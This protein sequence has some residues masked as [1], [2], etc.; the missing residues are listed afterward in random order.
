MKPIQLRFE[1]SFFIRWGLIVGMMLMMAMV[2]VL[3]MR[4][5]GW[6]KLVMPVGAL[7][8]L[9]LPLREWRI[10]AR[11][12]DDEGVTRHDGKRFLWSELR[13]L[14]E[15]NFVNRYGQTGSLNHLDIYFTNGRARILP[16]V[17]DRG[18]EAIRHIQQRHGKPAAA[19][20][21]AAPPA[22]EPKPEAKPTRCSLCG[23]LGEYHHAM[24]KHG[25]EEQDTSLPPAVKNLKFV[26]DLHP[27]TTRSPELLRCPGCGSYFLFKIS[28]EYLATG[29]EDEQELSRMTQQ[30]ADEILA[31][32]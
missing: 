5:G 6:W 16:M 12:I 25:R 10:A 1:T 2:P 31:A 22:P 14:Q 8:L 11:I 9:L 27:G 32:Q 17:L 13:R 18:Y 20:A 26:K 4:S 3:I 19:P 15:V 28:Y 24:Q 23:D 30:Q 29:S 7:L 21:P